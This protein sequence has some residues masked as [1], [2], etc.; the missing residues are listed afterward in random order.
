VTCR[1]W[2]ALNKEGLCRLCRRQAALARTTRRGVTAAEANRYGPQLFIVGTFRQRRRRAPAPDTPRGGLPPGYPAAHHQLVLFDTPRDLTRLR[3]AA[4]TEFRDPVPATAL[5][6]AA[7]E[8]AARH[9]W[10]RTRTAGA[11]S[12]LRALLAFQDAP[13][14]PIK[15][16]AVGELA[17]RFA[18]QPVL[19]ILAGT[20]MLDDDRQPSVTGWFDDKVSGLPEPM[21]GELRTWFQV[22]LDGSNSPPRRLPRSCT[23]ILTATRPPGGRPGRPLR[24]SG[25]ILDCPV[26]SAVSIGTCRAS[27]EPGAGAPAGSGSW[28]TPPT[29]SPSGASR[30]QAWMK[31]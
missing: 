26:Q 31:C 13:G 15:A 4:V 30:G 17:A 16:T 6:Q 8:H 19:D 5:L 29:C 2:C 21:A 7:G 11:R 24:H 14:A 3:P 23:T 25:H 12:A 18:A 28:S 10:S 20:G 9:G 1:G 22:M 27:R